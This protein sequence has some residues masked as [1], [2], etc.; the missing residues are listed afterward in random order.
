MQWHWGAII[1]AVLPFTDQALQHTHRYEV[2]YTFPSGAMYDRYVA[3]YA[4]QLRK[5]GLE[6]FAGKGLNYSRSFGTFIA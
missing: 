2:R 4:P 1:A 5:E 6:K 3:T